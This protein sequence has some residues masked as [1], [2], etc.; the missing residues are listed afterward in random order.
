MALQVLDCA[1]SELVSESIAD[2]FG[3]KGELG[4]PARMVDRDDEFL[5]SQR[6]RVG[7]RGDV[8]PDDLRPAADDVGEGLHTEEPLTRQVLID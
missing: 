8:R 5:T 3:E 6:P 2:R 4:R 1:P 7:M